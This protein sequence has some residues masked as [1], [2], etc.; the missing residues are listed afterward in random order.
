MHQAPSYPQADA[1][2]ERKGRQLPWLADSDS[3]MAISVMRSPRMTPS[4]QLYAIIREVSSLLNELHHRRFFAPCRRRP[5][6]RATILRVRPWRSD[7][8]SNGRYT[9]KTVTVGL[10][11]PYTR[12]IRVLVNSTRLRAPS[13]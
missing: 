1:S 7:R 6:P 11:A 10:M 8:R 5:S 12:E 9:R 13:K 3:L 4:Q 2:G